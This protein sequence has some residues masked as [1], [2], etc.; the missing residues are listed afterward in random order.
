MNHDSEQEEKEYRVRVYIVKHF[1]VT[2]KAL[3]EEDAQE[4]GVEI[5]ANEECTWFYK[6]DCAVL[7]DATEVEEL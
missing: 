6:G 1:D 5:V 4:I 2:V 7:Y 3:N